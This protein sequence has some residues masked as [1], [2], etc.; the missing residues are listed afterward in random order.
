M[1]KDR[2]AAH[3]KKKMEDYS[4]P[5]PEGLWERLEAEMS[6]SPKVVPM[7]R[8]RRF[9]V[10]VAAALVVSVSVLTAWLA[11]FWAEELEQPD[12]V[13]AEKNT[14]PVAPDE[15]PLLPSVSRPLSK[16]AVETPLL[17]DARMT[18]SL[19]SRRCSLCRRWMIRK[20]LRRQ[21]VRRVHDKQE[22]IFSLLPNQRCVSIAVHLIRNRCSGT[23]KC[24]KGKRKMLKTVIGQ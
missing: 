4:E 22:K 5:L 10:A 19:V 2:W 23:V 24:G 8:M 6:S 1:D 18:H 3:F 13:V 11:G 20:R 9:A 16:V 17:A 7:W 12:A 15:K 14:F 21:K